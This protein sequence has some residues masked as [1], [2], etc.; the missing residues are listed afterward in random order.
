MIIKMSTHQE[1]ITSMDMY[2]LN[3]NVKKHMKENV[4]EVRRK[5]NDFYS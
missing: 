3:N 1:V 5:L 2:I 4:T